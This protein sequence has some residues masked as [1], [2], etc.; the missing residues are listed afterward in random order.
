MM[1]LLQRVLLVGLAGFFLLGLCTPRLYA[2][3]DKGHKMVASI[4]LRQLNQG[5]REKILSILKHHPRWQQE[6]ADRMPEEVRN[7]DAAIQLEWSFQQAA[8]WPDLARDYQND[9]RDKFHRSV[10]HYIN[11]GLYLDEKE[12]EQFKKDFPTGSFE[13]PDKVEGVTNVIQ[14]LKFTR[15]AMKSGE[16]TSDADRAV[17]LAW[18]MHLVGDLHQPM[19]ST[20]LYSGNLFPSGDRGG[21]EIALVQRNN[22]HALWDSFPGSGKV[23]IKEARDEALSLMLDE[24]FRKAGETARENLDEVVWLKD[25]QK[26]AEIY[27]YTDEVLAPLR[28]YKTL[29]ELKKNPLGLSKGYMQSGGNIAKMRVVEAGYRLGAVLKEIAAEK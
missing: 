12:A 15:R 25:G 26:L 1:R 5:E 28:N 8:I 7:G 27:V 4:A 17:Y 13:V 19:H 3:A 10:W 6:F 16:K 18:I 22:L 2:W 21:N 24:E 14:A 23:T 20:S 9:V 29:E 11:H